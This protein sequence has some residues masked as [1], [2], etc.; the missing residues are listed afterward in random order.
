METINCDFC[1]SYESLKVSEQTDIIHHL[2]EEVFSV[3]RCKNCGLIYTNPRPSRSDIG[4]FYS[5]NYSFHGG[6]TLRMFIKE[7]LGPFVKWFANSLLAIISTLILPVSKLLASQVKP[8]V[9]DPVLAL[10]KGGE[11]RNFLDIGSDINQRLHV[12]NCQF[13]FIIFR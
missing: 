11:V 8:H 2:T 10:L 1:G 4:N 13:I 9:E 7:K 5:S 6:S 3:V 12:W